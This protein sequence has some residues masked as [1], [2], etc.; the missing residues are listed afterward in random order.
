VVGPCALASA[1][2]KSGRRIG[3]GPGVGWK[4]NRSDRTGEPRFDH[5]GLLSRAEALGIPQNERGADS[6]DHD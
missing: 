6:R 5:A 2:S 3:A 1:S 4:R